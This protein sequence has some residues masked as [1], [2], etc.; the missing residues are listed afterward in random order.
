[1][2]WN[3]IHLFILAV[4][5]ILASCLYRST[6]RYMARFYLAMAHREKARRLYVRLWLVLLL[7]YHYVYTWVAPGDYG[8]MFSTVVCAI[9]FSFRRSDRWL[10]VLHE[11]SL[12][13]VIFSFAALA[14][15]VIP[16]LFSLSFSVAMFL[17][18]SMFYPSSR[19]IAIGWSS[20]LEY[21]WIRNTGLLVRIYYGRNSLNHHVCGQWLRKIVRTMSNHLKQ[22]KNER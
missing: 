11:Q 1:M 21:G 4:P 17:V 6:G 15:S 7:L 12:L 20:E 10:R 13:F 16:H 19:I 18:A 8:I 22:K 14:F 5:V 3:I 2:I 9:M